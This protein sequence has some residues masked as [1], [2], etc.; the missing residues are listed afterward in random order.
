M[1]PLP[2]QEATRCAVFYRLLKDLQDSGYR[3]YEYANP[4]T[5]KIEL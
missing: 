1:F 5:V 4:L 3:A 2:A